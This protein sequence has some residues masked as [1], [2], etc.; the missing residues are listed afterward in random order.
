[1]DIEILSQMSLSKLQSA[2]V[3]KRLSPVEVVEITLAQIEAVEG[4]INALYG[5]RADEARAEARASEKR[6]KKS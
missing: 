6:Q 2:F 4:K 1:M 3:A 5:V